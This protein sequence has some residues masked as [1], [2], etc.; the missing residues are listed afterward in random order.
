M[1]GQGEHW[2]KTVCVSA[3]NS[4]KELLK[5]SLPSLKQGLYNCWGPDEGGWGFP[6]QGLF[7]LSRLSLTGHGNIL[8]MVGA[9]MMASKSL[10]LSPDPEG[11]HP[12]QSPRIFLPRLPAWNLVYQET[13]S[14]SLIRSTQMWK[15]RLHPTERWNTHTYVQNLWSRRMSF[16]SALVGTLRRFW[17]G[18]AGFLCEKIF[19]Y[20]ET[21]TER[22]PMTLG[23][24]GHGN[25]DS[26]MIKR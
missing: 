12:F 11:Q 2:Y 13:G 7:S 10:C 23:M 1:T 6:A 16:S 5:S 15:N 9:R 25:T 3:V 8:L 24:M 17:Q 26:S 22:N 14:D 20:R 19:K 4:P 21:K 18:F